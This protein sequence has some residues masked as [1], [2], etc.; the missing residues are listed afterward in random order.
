M[1]GVA[2]SPTKDAVP[3]L[4]AV[5]VSGSRTVW[6]QYELDLLERSEGQTLECQRRGVSRQRSSQRS[7]TLEAEQGHE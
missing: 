2:A 1:P 7:S 6:R 3:R 4:D 5:S